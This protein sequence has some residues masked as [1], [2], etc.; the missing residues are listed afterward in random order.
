MTIYKTQS[1]KDVADKGIYNLLFDNIDFDDDHVV[2][3]EMFGKRKQITL[4][5]LKLQIKQLGVGLRKRFGLKPGDIVLMIMG[6]SIMFPVA[7]YACQF[8]GLVVAFANP[9]YTR[10]ELRHVCSLVK[11]KAII[12]TST[13]LINVSRASL[14]WPQCIVMD[15]DVG[16]GTTFFRKLLVSEQE[17]RDAAPA[18]VEDREATAYLP[19]S[20]GTTGLPK[21]VMI[22][23]RNVCYMVATL[24]QIPGFHETP[25]RGIAV[26]PFFHAMALLNSVHL[27][28]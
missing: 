10:K 23:H 22:S 17:A 9:A 25:K 26:A 11:P 16:S 7:L 14:M 18:P 24:A 28:M 5:Q 19:C 27:P 15:T 20:S 1:V 21:A 6:N 12:T 4:G 2:F 3:K 8:A 13:L